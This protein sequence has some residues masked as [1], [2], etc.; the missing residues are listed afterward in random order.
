[1]RIKTVSYS[2]LFQMP[3]NRF[4]N[5]RITMEAEVE[6]GEDIPVVMEQLK[7]QVFQASAGFDKLAKRAREILNNLEAYTGRE[8]N[9]AEDFT[10]QFRIPLKRRQA[11][12]KL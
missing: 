5:E 1:M 8:I 10:G 2:R 9:W 12:L 4:E 6:R 3:N 11:R 7:M